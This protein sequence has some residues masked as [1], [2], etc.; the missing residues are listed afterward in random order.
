MIP[1]TNFV[2]ARRKAYQSPGK[3]C[4]V[5]AGSYL[6]Y[7]RDA[8]YAIERVRFGKFAGLWVISYVGGAPSLH[9]YRKTT[10]R[11]CLAALELRALRF[12]AQYGERAS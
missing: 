12:A 6:L 1:I 3:V 8:L 9:I 5:L 4:K 2:D 11:A 7:S 10:M